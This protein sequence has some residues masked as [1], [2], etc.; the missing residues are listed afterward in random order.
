MP[1]LDE[2]LRRLAADATQPDAARQYAR[3][4]LAGEAIDSAQVA[5]I[6]A[7]GEERERAEKAR[8]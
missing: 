1:S 8:D 5:A 7:A 2:R 3:N 6:R 4:M